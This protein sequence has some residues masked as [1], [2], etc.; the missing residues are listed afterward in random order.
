MLRFSFSL[1]GLY[2]AYADGRYT[3]YAAER[4]VVRNELITE[5]TRGALYPLLLA[6][7]GGL[8]H[9]MSIGVDWNR[10]SS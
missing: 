7:R 2:A 3:L 10:S 5:I 8:V 9:W 1:A 4:Y 6:L